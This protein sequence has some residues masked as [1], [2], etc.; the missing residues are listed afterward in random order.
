MFMWMVLFMIDMFML[1]STHYIIGQSNSVVGYIAGYIFGY[2][3]KV[4][5]KKEALWVLGGSGST[6]PPTRINQ[7]LGWLEVDETT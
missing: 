3:V 5:A 7:G 1:M 2:V 4:Q 6:E